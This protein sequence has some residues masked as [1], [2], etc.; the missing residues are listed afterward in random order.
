MCQMRESLRLPRLTTSTTAALQADLLDTLDRAIELLEQWAVAPP[1]I[2]TT[3]D[4]VGSSTAV[5]TAV[6]SEGGRKRRREAEEMEAEDEEGEEEETEQESSRTPHTPDTRVGPLRSRTVGDRPRAIRSTPRAPAGCSRQYT[7]EEG[8]TTQLSWLPSTCT[9]DDV[10][11]SQRSG[12]LLGQSDTEALVFVKRVHEIILAN[13][14]DS[15]SRFAELFGR[16]I[17][18]LPATEMNPD[19]EGFARRAY[20]YV[21]TL[22]RESRRVSVHVHR[23]IGTF[24]VEIHRLYPNSPISEVQTAICNQASAEKAAYYR[25]IRDECSESGC[26]E[27]SAARESSQCRPPC[28]LTQRICRLQ[29]CNY[30]NFTMTFMEQCRDLARLPAWSPLLR[31]SDPQGQVRELVSTASKVASSVVSQGLPRL[32]TGL[33]P[34]FDLK[35]GESPVEAV[36]YTDGDGGYI[37]GNFFPGLT[38]YLQERGID[39]SAGSITLQGHNYVLLPFREEFHDAI[40]LGHE[41]SVQF[42]ESPHAQA[43]TQR[44]PSHA[45][46]FEALVAARKNVAQA[47]SLWIVPGD[48]DRYACMHTYAYMSTCTCTCT[49]ACGAVCLVTLARVFT[50][51]LVFLFF[52]IVTYSTDAQ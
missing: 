47:V 30:L 49:R 41:Y 31:C 50:L 8:G 13:P 12:T 40:E 11:A 28:D 6:R 27:C 5:S 15:V 1:T 29:D 10:V 2:V 25:R 52:G 35:K 16:A 3:D 21:S 37:V 23:R 17:E 45:W 20:R 9:Y 44:P 19:E 14:G 33:V 38:E 36:Q 46:G 32:T 22:L 51:I 18:S 4:R 34:V 7:R 26:T 39:V 24:L 42:D 43:A 48:L